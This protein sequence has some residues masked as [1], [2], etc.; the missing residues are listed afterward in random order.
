MKLIADKNGT[1]LIAETQAESEVLFRAYQN[2][3]HGT[4][5]E[6][7][8]ET[9]QLL[10]PEKPK[11]AYNKKPNHKNKHWT[12]SEQEILAPYVA[13]PNTPYGICQKLAKKLGRTSAGVSAKLYEL[14]LSARTGA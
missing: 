13:L 11:R 7:T 8:P 6:A 1:T 2:H 9:L 5:P 14:R 12:A 4:K 3:I 10:T